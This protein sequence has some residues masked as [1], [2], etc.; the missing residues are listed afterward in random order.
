M[1]TRQYGN[2]VITDS[3]FW[4]QHRSNNDFL[5]DR[6]LLQS[7]QVKRTSQSAPQCYINELFIWILKP[8]D[9]I[10]EMTSGFIVE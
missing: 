10:L 4:P 9:C 6:T 8:L 1:K 2:F 3:L 5:I 7:N